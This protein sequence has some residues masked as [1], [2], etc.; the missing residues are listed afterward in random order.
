MKI[1]V[2]VPLAV[3][4]ADLF[5]VQRRLVFLEQRGDPDRTEEPITG[6]PGTESGE[7]RRCEPGPTDGFQNGSTRSI[8]PLVRTVGSA[9]HFTRYN[10]GI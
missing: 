3:D 9:R 6:R 2:G 7:G 5:R 1:P 10:Y 4:G 8:R